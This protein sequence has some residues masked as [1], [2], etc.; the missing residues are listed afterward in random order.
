MLPCVYAE[1]IWSSCCG[2]TPQPRSCGGMRRCRGFARSAT[3]SKSPSTARPR[4]GT[5]WW[6]APTACT[7]RS[8]DSILGRDEPRS[9]L[10]SA[11]SWRFVTANPGV[12]CWCA[13]SG[14]AGTL[15]LIPLSGDQVYGY[16]S[17]TGHGSVGERPGMAA[18]H[19]RPLPRAG[20][21]GRLVR[22]AH[23]GFAVPLARPR[24][25]G[26]RTWH[27]R[28]GRARSVMQPTPPPRCGPKALPWPPR[29]LSSSPISW[30]RTTTGPRSVSSSSGVGGRGSSTC[31][32]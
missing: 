12:D 20:A 15:L 14:P 13:W 9:S 22:I 28:K 8:E 5:T 2:L 18:R 27:R 29:M 6:W 19:V 7:R 4:N 1:A 24:G 3:R 32:T 30:P 10:L 26:S 23:T 31:S 11:A 16:A 25:D 21:P 17:A